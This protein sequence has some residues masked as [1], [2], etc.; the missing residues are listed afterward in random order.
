MIFL[1]YLFISGYLSNSK[2]K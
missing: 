2:P 1:I